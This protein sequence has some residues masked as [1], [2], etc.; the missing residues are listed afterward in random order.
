MFLEN[1]VLYC[2]IRI[3]YKEGREEMSVFYFKF[4]GGWL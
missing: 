3:F 1:I 2:E 4:G